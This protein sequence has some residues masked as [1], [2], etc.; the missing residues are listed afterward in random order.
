M[1]IKHHHYERKE[2]LSIDSLGKTMTD[3]SGVIFV[4][5]VSNHSQAANYDISRPSIIVK[6]YQ[7]LLKIS[8]IF[9]RESKTPVRLVLV[10]EAS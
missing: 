4:L 6:T 7:G 5:F 10:P 1:F 9:V 3:Y 2:L 8:E